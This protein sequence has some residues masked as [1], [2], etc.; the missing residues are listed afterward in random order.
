VPENEKIIVAS[1]LV[2]HLKS[3]LLEF[4]APMEPGDYEFLCTFPGHRQTM[5]G[6]MRVVN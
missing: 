3:Q 2:D 1:K 6:M 5:H 4:R